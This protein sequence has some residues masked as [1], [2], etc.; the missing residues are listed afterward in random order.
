VCRAGS[1]EL[2]QALGIVGDERSRGKF[3]ITI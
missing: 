1:D 2:P 3:A